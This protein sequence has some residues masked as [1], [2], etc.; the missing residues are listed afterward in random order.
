MILREVPSLCH[1]SRT[2]WALVYYYCGIF[3]NMRKRNIFSCDLQLISFSLRISREINWALWNV[4]KSSC[5]WCICSRSVPGCAK[6]SR[7]LHSLTLMHSP[8][9]SFSFTSSLLFTFL[10]FLLVL[11]NTLGFLEVC[12]WFQQ[13][14]SVANFTLVEIW[15]VYSYIFSSQ[16][17]LIPQFLKWQAWFLTRLRLHHESICWSHSLHSSITSSCASSL[18][19][20]ICLI[21]TNRA[22]LCMLRI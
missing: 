7:A 6:N 22:L 20:H 11:E 4:I 3:S 10:G 1:W 17:N 9:M 13:V 8:Y 15:H 19:S 21:Q 5:H 16:G 14:I 2:A 18:Q 12:Y